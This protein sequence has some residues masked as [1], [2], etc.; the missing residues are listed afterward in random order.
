M[1]SLMSPDKKAYAILKMDGSL[2]VFD[3]SDG[4]LV[5]SANNT[6]FVTDVPVFTLASSGL[7]I[8][9]GSFILWSEHVIGVDAASYLTV[10]DDCNLVLYNQNGEIIWQS[11]AFCIGGQV[12]PGTFAG[13]GRYMPPTD[14]EEEG[15]T[16]DEDGDSDE[17]M[18]VRHKKTSSKKA[19]GK[20]TH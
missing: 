14:D 2:S 17:D 19:R 16:D 11:Y 3:T 13:A 1:N 15:E 6:K 12:T 18:K 4:H 10:Q 20:K 7:V 9:S 5:W 8:S